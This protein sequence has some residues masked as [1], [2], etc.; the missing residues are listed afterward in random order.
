MATAA[1]HLTTVITRWSDL[2]DALTARNTST[3]PPAG[4]RHHLH[5]RSADEAEW[6]AAHRYLDRSPDQ[7]GETPAPIRLD[8]LDTM[9]EVEADLVRLADITA[10]EVQRP[11]MSRAPAHWLP[12]D[13]ARRNEL[14][15]RD[16]AD[17]RRWRYPGHRD[18]PLAA[19]WLT[20][21]LSDGPGPFVRLHGRHRI[22][23]AAAAEQAA[24]RVETALALVRRSTP[25]AW[26]CP[27]CRGQL[28][29]HGGDGQAPAVRCEDCGRTWRERVPA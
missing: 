12:A 8:L 29:V 16:A 24:T 13:R 9:R 26:P 4:L 25:V 14:A 1:E 10:A 2:I 27:H 23:I 3:W 7:L 5:S 6:A 17:P 28:A 21:R 15:D 19:R 20:A 11:A 22:T 18:A